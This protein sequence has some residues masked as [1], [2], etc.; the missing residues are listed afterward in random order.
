M[1]SKPNNRP[2]PPAP[3]RVLATHEQFAEEA[4][5]AAQ[6]YL[7]QV[8]EIKQLIEDRDGW[9]NRAL[10]AEGEI[11]QLQTR[12]AELESQIDNRNSQVAI[13]RDSYKETLAIVSAQ[14]TT[15]SKILLDGF[16]VIRSVEQKVAPM[17]ERPAADERRA[18]RQDE[19][20]DDPH[21]ERHEGA[22][23]L[24]HFLAAGPR[25]DDDEAYE[26]R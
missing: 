25:T 3:R 20:H 13:E 16:A 22:P 23:P 7:D 15:A 17:T 24:P 4:G 1:Q 11:R 8:A 14:Y 5:R 18:E 12:I 19:H 6:R 26:Q 2:A 10:L 21:D 9:C